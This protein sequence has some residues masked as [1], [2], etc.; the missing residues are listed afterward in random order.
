MAYASVIEIWSRWAPPNERA[1]MASIGDMGVYAG[2]MSSFM[3]SGWILYEMGWATLFHITGIATLFWAGIWYVLVKNDPADA[4]WITDDEKKYIKEQMKTVVDDQKKLVY[5]WKDLLT[6]V[7]FWLACMV[8][9]AYGVGFAFMMMNLPQ[10]IKDMNDIDIKKIGYIST[11]PQI[12]ALIAMPFAG[13]IFDYMRSNE[14]LSLTNVHKLYACI[15]LISGVVTFLVAGLWPNFIASVVCLSL[16]Q[17]CVSCTVL[18]NQ[19]VM[20]D[21]APRYAAFMVSIASSCYTVA[22]I[23]TPMIVGYTVT[24]HSRS[25]WN[26][27]FMIFGILFVSTSLICLKFLKVKLQRWANYSPDESNEQKT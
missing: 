19:I 15:G 1:K 11:I 6:C 24:S 13:Y 16:F 2:L 17:V 10:Y 12:C 21:L 4:E 9:F 27:C 5:P 3:V 22:L 23:L 26:I 8:K 7:P 14:I 25:Q 18:E 20:L